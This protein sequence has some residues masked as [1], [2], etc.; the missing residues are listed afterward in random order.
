MRDGCV[1]APTPIIINSKTPE[2]E[3]SWKILSSLCGPVGAKKLIENASI[4]GYIDPEILAVIAENPK[5]D[6][7]VQEALI[8][9]RLYPEYAAHP[10]SGAFGRK[11]SFN[12]STVS[13]FSAG[14]TKNTLL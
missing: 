11:Y 3:A 12:P 14:H 8:F 2:V 10:K 13:A 9:D 7:T 1:A 5:L 4:P 6:S